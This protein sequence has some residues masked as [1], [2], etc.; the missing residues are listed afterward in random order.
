MRI[1][2]STRYG[3]TFACPRKRYW[4]TEYKGRGIQIASPSEDLLYGS[5]VHAGCEAMAKGL[6]FDEAYQLA[7]V[8]MFNIDPTILTVDGLSHKDELLALLWG[9]LR[10]YAEYI[11]PNLSLRFNF[12]A[13]EQEIAIPLSEN[14]TYCTRLDDILE[15]KETGLKYNLNYKTSSYVND[16][17]SQMSHS[18]QLMMEAEAARLHLGIAAVGTLIIAFDKGRSYGAS[19]AE[20]KRGLSGKRRLSPLTYLYSKGDDPWD[21]GTKYS[22]EYKSGWKR[23]PTFVPPLSSE[24]VWNKILTPGDKQGLFSELTPIYFDQ[25]MVEDVRDQILTVERQVVNMNSSGNFPQNFHNCIQ[26]GGY[27]HHTC[28]Y[29]PLC[30]DGEEPEMLLGGLYAWREYNHPLEETVR[31]EANA[32]S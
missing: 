24:L 16:L 19:D 23:V 22:T 26:D 29:H 21:A 14:V 20:K 11:L 8:E 32:P 25:G 13:I 3:C 30:W 15:D 27:M 5:A 18:T 2:D 6:S 1:V 10:V 7:T 4:F 17:P 12:L 9:H 28:P 31:E